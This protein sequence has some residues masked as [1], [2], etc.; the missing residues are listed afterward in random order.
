VGNLKEKALLKE[1]DVD[2]MMMIMMMVIMMTIM[3]IV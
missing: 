2:W 1:A 3:I